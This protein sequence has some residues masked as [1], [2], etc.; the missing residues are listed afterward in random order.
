VADWISHLVR[1]CLKPD[2]LERRDDFA[3]Q[4]LFQGSLSL[5]AR[6]MAQVWEENYTQTQWLDYDVF[7][8]S[9]LGAPHS[10]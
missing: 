8:A 3:M 9:Q 1:F 2:A 4:E 7:S 6:K 5:K 10:C